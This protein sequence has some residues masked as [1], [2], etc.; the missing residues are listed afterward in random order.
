MKFADQKLLLLQEPDL[1]GI[2]AA[3][4]NEF[5]VLLDN[6]IHLL[7]QQQIVAFSLVAFSLCLPN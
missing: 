5:G 6:I 2:L 3:H 4:L 7:R 1:L